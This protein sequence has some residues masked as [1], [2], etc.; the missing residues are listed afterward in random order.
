M[1]T[2]GLG[3]LPSPPDERDFP[4]AALYAAAGIEPAAVIPDAYTAPDPLPVVF[5]RRAHAMIRSPSIFGS[6]Y[7]TPAT[8]PPP[9]S[10][11]CS[12]PSWPRP[13]PM[14]TR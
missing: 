3:W 6:G 11:P 12:A 14:L 8:G 13:S 10:C 7:V 2:F 1:T 9:R 4:L 5:T